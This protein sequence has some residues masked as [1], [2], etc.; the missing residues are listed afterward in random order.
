M[1]IFLCR[2]L[3]A[4]LVIVGAVCIALVLLTT[5]LVVGVVSGFPVVSKERRTSDSDDTDQDNSTISY[6]TKKNT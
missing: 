2:W 5:H 1:F 6:Q 3:A 4:L